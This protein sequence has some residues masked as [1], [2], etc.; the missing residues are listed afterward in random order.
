[1][2]KLAIKE[3]EQDKKAKTKKESK[4]NGKRKDIAIA[5]GAMIVIAVILTWFIPSGYFSGTTY[6]EYGMNR[7]GLTDLTTLGYYGAYFAIDKLVFILVVGGFYGLLSKIGAY[8]KITTSIAK[9]LKGK[10]IISLVVTSVIVALLTSIS[11]VSYAIILFVPFLISIFTKM[12]LDKMSAFTATF[13]SILIGI[14]GATFGTDGLIGFNSYFAANLGTDVLGSTLIIRG[15][16]LLVSLALFNFFIVLHAK[17]VLNNKKSEEVKV[18]RF[19]VAENTDKKVKTLPLIIVLSLVT[20]ITLL[21]VINWSGF[22]LEIFNEFH[23]WLT[24]LTIGEDITIF[25][26]ILGNSALAFGAWDLFTLC[27]LLFVA[28]IIIAIISKVSFSEYLS[29]IGEGF[30]KMGKPAVVLVGVFAVFIAVYMT[31]IIPT[32]TNNLL[33]ASETPSIN[34]DYNGSGSPYFNIDTDN[35]LK[36]DYNL[37]NLDI[38]KDDKCDLNCDT[39]KNGWPDTN[40]DFDGDGEITKTDKNLAEELSGKST[41]NLDSNGDGIA[42]VNMTTEFSLPKTILA[43]LI[44]NLFHVDLGY[45][46]YTVGTYLVS[47]F[48]AIALNI[49]F[50]VY[51]LIY[52]FLQLFVPTSAILMLGLAYSNIEYKTWFKYAWIFL[53]SILAILAVLF[54]ILAL[55]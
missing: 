29:S 35:D 21:G 40:L 22:G 8:Q 19:A 39:D 46:G 23:T 42:D 27:T 4:I 48:G 24:G 33:P 13:G 7:I 43:S 44:T 10:E 34:L 5:I 36:A 25:A 11:T 32:I 20:V 9:K 17:K 1:M 49:I 52:G 18:D 51:V 26:Y 54:L 55:I 50:L 47:S 3:K 6:Y 12:N 30:L 37:I 16:L 45:T 2:K 31:P 38:D 53:L 15:I 28:S 14:L 41:I